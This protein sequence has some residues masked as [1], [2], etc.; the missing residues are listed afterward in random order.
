MKFLDLKGSSVA[1]STLRR[2]LGE[3]SP[4]QSW[5]ADW[6]WWPKRSWQLAGHGDWGSGRCENHPGR[7][8]DC[9][10]QGR[11]RQGRPLEARRYSPRDWSSGEACCPRS[12]WNCSLSPSRTP[13]CS[14]SRW[15]NCSRCCCCRCCCP[16]SR[17]R[18]PCSR[19]AGVQHCPPARKEREGKPSEQTRKRR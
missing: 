11:S 19:P 2:R 4:N 16:C 10:L 17:E 1:R 8:T 12:R 5:Q 9:A 7:R 6:E 14:P 18:R 3:M 15:R 13:S